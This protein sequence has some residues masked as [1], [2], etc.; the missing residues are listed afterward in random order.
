MLTS[1]KNTAASIYEAQYYLRFIEL[2]GGE[3][4]LLNPDGIYGAET[5]E[6]VMRFQKQNN[7]PETGRIDNETW[8]KIY[9]EYKKAK[10]ASEAARAVRIYPLEISKMKIGDEFDEIYVLQFLLR[11]N[12]LRHKKTSNVTLSGIYDEATAAAVSEL[13][14]LFGFKVTGEADKI[15]WNRLADYHNTKYFYE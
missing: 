9:K 14:A 6:A 11:K 13:Q 2:F 7:L 15:F 4:R 1:M 12:E 5:K 3:T 10:E 8:E